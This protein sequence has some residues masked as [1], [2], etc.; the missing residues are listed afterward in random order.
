MIVQMEIS[1]SH[2]Q[3]DARRFLYNLNFEVSGQLGQEQSY[4]FAMAYQPC[5][6]VIDRFPIGTI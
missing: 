4:D 2:Y 3:V 1:I 5:A 6:L